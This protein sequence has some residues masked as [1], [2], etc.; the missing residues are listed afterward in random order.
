MVAPDIE[1]QV[2]SA[3]GAILFRDPGHRLIPILRAKALRLLQM[4]LQPNLSQHL[5]D[6]LLAHVV[7]TGEV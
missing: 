4:R 3:A 5:G 2:C 1:A 6:F 7:W